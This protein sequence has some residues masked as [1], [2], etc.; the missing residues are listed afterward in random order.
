MNQVQLQHKE[1]EKGDVFDTSSMAESI[2][3]VVVGVL[4]ITIGQNVIKKHHFFS[5]GAQWYK[6]SSWGNPQGEILWEP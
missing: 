4:S 6:N 1:K 2:P 3:P 5:I